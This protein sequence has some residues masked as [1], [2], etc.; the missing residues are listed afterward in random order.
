[1]CRPST[2]RALILGRWIVAVAAV[3]VASFGGLRTLK[4]NATAKPVALAPQALTLSTE[5]RGR[6]GAS[7]ATLPLAFESNQGQTDAQQ[8][9]YTARAKGYTLFLTAHDT[10]FA[11]PSS[12]RSAVTGAACNYGLVQTKHVTSPIAQENRTAGIHLQLVETNRRVQIAASNQLPGRTSYFIGDDSTKWHANVPQYAR[13]S[14]R[15]VYP[16]VSRVFHGVER[17]LE[18][19]LVVLPKANPASIRFAVSGVTKM[20]TDNAGNL[21]LSSTAEISCCTSPSPIRRRTEQVSR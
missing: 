15:N 6:V 4:V 11:L 20:A 1:V 14:Y 3:A 18:F 10:V 17:Q 8:V 12:S 5:Q 19:D 9:K 13:V 21:V 16:G 2:R 7:L